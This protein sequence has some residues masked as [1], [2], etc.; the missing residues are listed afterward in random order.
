MSNEYQSLGNERVIKVSRS[1][2]PPNAKGPKVV[3]G[4]SPYTSHQSTVG[5]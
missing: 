5:L 3:P 4:G 2:L 1:G